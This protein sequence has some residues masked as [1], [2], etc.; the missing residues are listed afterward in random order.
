MRESDRDDILVMA[1]FMVTRDDVRDCA[2]E[3]EIPEEQISD[4][5]I[6]LVKQKVSRSV[7][8]WRELV[9]DMVKEAVKEDALGCPLGL[10]CSAACA[11]R[12]IGGCPLPGRVR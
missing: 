6:E 8:A 7:G 9:K 4:R 5:V 2:H 1:V 12:E 10:V 3:S 11:W